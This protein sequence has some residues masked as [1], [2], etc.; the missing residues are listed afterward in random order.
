[1]SSH[2][3]LQGTLHTT[4]LQHLALYIPVFCF[5]AYLHLQL[6]GGVRQCLS[7]LFCTS[8][9]YRFWQGVHTQKCLLNEWINWSHIK[10]LKHVDNSLDIIG[11]NKNSYAKMAKPQGFYLS[12]IFFR[13]FIFLTWQKKE[14]QKSGLKCLFLASL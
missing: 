6:R 3:C 4:L 1:M 5:S 2:I 11:G 14:G 9:G 7:Y 13:L 12:Q 8:T 10:V